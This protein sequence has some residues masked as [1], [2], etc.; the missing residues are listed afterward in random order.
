MDIADYHKSYSFEQLCSTADL[1]I[2]S[3]ILNVLLDE[4]DTSI[5]RVFKVTVTK[6]TD[7]SSKQTR[8]GRNNVLFGYAVRGCVV[9]NELT[10]Y[11]LSDDDYAVVCKRQHPIDSDHTYFVK[12]F[13]SI[14]TQGIP[15]VKYIVDIPDVLTIF[16]RT[17]YTYKYVF[18]DICILCKAF[19]VEFPLMI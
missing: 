3:Q 4:L 11:T 10:E 7:I 18:H 1:F 17:E 13:D 12:I 9:D 2:G 6:D 14:D 16:K 15:N 19:G 5:D 8:L